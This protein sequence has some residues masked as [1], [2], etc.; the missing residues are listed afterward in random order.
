[1]GFNAWLRDFTGLSLYDFRVLDLDG[2]SEQEVCDLF[3]KWVEFCKPS[4]DAVKK[5]IEAAECEGFDVS[6][7]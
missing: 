3:H 2:T 7:A 5:A 4:A 6:A 1:M